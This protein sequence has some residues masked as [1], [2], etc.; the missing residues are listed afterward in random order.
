[1]VEDFIP[2]ID[3]SILKIGK[4][5]EEKKAKEDVDSIKVIHD[6]DQFDSFCS[7]GFSSPLKITRNGVVEYRKFIIK[8]IGVADVIEQYQKNSPRP[9]SLIKTYK[10]GSEVANQLGAKHDVVVREID[11]SDPAYIRLREQA[12]TEA[13]QM[14]VI[15]S[16]AYD[17]KHPVT[18]DIVVKGKEMSQPNEII[19]RDGALLALRRLGMSGAHF[20]ALVR[21]INLLTRDADEAE[22]LE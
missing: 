17:L 6:L 19:D 15:S 18:G 5:A 14:I 7:Y 8:S 12:D 3:P 13:S 10:R 2:G 21:D 20:S 1:V 4:E 22:R 11:E 9:P 16:L